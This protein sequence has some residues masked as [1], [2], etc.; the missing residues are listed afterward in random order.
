VVS[1]WDMNC[2]S[3]IMPFGFSSVFVMPEFSTIVTPACNIVNYG[4]LCIC[5]C[6]LVRWILL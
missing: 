6:V 1:F 2:N 5:L 4:L 3:Q